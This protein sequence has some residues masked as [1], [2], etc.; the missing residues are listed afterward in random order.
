VL[1]KLAVEYRALSAEP[2]RLDEWWRRIEA[3]RERYPLGYEESSGSEIKP[4]YMIKALYEATGGD[5][6]VT[7]D[8]GQHQ[9]WAAQYFHF[10]EP[11]RWINSGGLGTMGF[12]LPSAMGAAVGCPDRVVCCIAGDG[13]VQ[14]NMQELATCAQE[15]IPIKVF[16]MNNGYLGMVR[17]WQ[18]LFWEK[19]YSHVDMGSFPD[20]VK[21]AEAYGAT[22]MRF[23]DKRTLVEDVRRAIAT[24]GPVLVDVRVTREENTYP[25]I[26]AGKAA[27]EMVG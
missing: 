5:A 3:W 13:S 26:P 25:M 4:Q 16:I 9:M 8:V 11:R 17:Q 20:F 6:I 22:G 15:S 27:R 19:R 2:S 21:L 7:S 1:A 12:G 24:E 18:E 10:A 14:M 23:E